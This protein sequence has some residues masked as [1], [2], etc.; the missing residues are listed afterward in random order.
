MFP[1]ILALR[2]W[3][4]WNLKIEIGLALAALE[5]ANT[6]I[7][8][9]YS[10]RFIESVHGESLDSSTRNVLIYCSQRKVPRILASGVALGS[11]RETLIYLGSP[12]LHW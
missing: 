9:I 6:I 7:S 12:S 8:A 4:V 2:T 10:A 11:G 1:V 5:V 3:A